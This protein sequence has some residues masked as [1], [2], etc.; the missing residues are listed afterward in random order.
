MQNR[1]RTHTDYRRVGELFR[2]LGIFLGLC[3]RAAALGD[4]SWKPV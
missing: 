3:K 2:N 4:L 1:N